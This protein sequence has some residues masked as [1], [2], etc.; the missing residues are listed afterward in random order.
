MWRG[1]TELV[2]FIFF[3]FFF[4]IVLPP[5]LC[6]GRVGLLN[7]LDLPCRKETHSQ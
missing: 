3:Q 1:N 4:L 7:K 6:G 5:P 2:T